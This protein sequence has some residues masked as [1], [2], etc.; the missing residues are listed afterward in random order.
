MRRSKPSYPEQLLHLLSQY[1]F[2]GN[3]RELRGMIYDAI[4]TLRG[5]TISLQQFH[6][7]MKQE[8]DHEPT[9]SC[10]DFTAAKPGLQFP[11]ILPTLKES[12]RLLILEAMRRT[13]DNQ[14]MAAR[15]L[16]IS[17][18]TLARHLQNQD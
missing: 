4:S 3:I 18:Q 7:H 1:T 8:Q 6:L 11:G 14:S 15:L 2:P 13:N 9:D 17:R 16:G 10:N 12:N 5:H